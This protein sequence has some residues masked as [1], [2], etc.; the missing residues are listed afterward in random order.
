MVNETDIVEKALFAFLCIA[1]C[2]RFTYGKRPAERDPPADVQVQSLW[3]N[4]TDYGA[5][6]DGITDDTDEIQAAID[7][8]PITG[9]TVFFPQGTYVVS[10]AIIVPFKITLQGVGA[11]ASII[12]FDSGTDT[13][14]I[15]ATQTSI[16]PYVCLR[17]LNIR[18]SGR[19]TFTGAGILFQG[20]LMGEIRNCEISGVDTGIRFD[21]T[22]VGS[23]NSVLTCRIVQC[24][25][26]SGA[27]NAASVSIGVHLYGD[28]THGPARNIIKDTLIRNTDDYAAYIQGAATGDNTFDNCEITGNTGNG[29]LI[30][31]GHYNRVQNCRFENTA[32]TGYAIDIGSKA[33]YTII[34]PGNAYIVGGNDLIRNQ[35]DAT[36][37]LDY[38]HTASRNSPGLASNEGIGQLL[39]NGQLEHWDRNTA[40]NWSTTNGTLTKETT[41]VKRGSASAKFV[42]ATADS[43]FYQ[44][45][46]PWSSYYKGRAIT[47]S[48][49]VWADSTDAKLQIISYGTWNSV[50]HTGDS[51]WEH[52]TVT[53]DAVGS[54]ATFT[55]CQLY[56]SGGCTAYIDGA[57][58]I[59]GVVGRPFAPHPS[60]CD[61]YASDTWDPA[62]IADGDKEAKDVTVTGAALGDFA[63]ASFSL[64]VADLQLSA[65]VTAADTVTCVL[66]NNTGGAVDL[67]SGTVYIKVLKRQIN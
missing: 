67:G 30:G 55:R 36:Y 40:V 11:G 53:C 50:S 6:G 52:L 28:E 12:S 38:S 59:E 61:Y 13:A 60:D 18:G 63:I 14:I 2:T 33:D 35:G 42:Y 41:T 62:S 57:M 34:G 58:V 9:G 3:R 54:S 21:G 66:S 31:G 15:D 43:Y 1:L 19:T 32:I 16:T 5:A 22:S 64:D 46:A 29:I 44:D 24:Q 4:V 49:W 8:T 48:A 39:R 27:N 23:G 20:V 17:D 45:I 26:G 10:S 7:A 25:I 51:S 65:D 47:F 37:M 56:L